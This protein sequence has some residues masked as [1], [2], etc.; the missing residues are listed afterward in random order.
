MTESGVGKVEGTRLGE[1]DGGRKKEKQ[2][3]DEV[4]ECSRG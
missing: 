2:S 4:K 1:R 3:E